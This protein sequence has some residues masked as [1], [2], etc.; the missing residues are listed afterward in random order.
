MMP[1]DQDI[2][3]LIKNDMPSEKV[4]SAAY[5]QGML[6]LRIAIAKL[7]KEGKSSLEEAIRL[8]PPDMH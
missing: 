3:K 5:K 1:I 2:R 4:T 7:L 8:A 6:P